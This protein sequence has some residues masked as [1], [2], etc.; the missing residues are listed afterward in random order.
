[1]RIQERQREDVCILDLAGS[2]LLEDGGGQLRDAVAGLL[3]AGKKKLVLNLGGITHVDSGGLG[4]MVQCHALAVCQ[5]ASLKLANLTQRVRD[6]LAI[7]KLV[8]IFDTYER[9]DEAV[10]SF[11]LS[12]A[13]QG[14]GW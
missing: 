12:P 14:A 11:G 6:L 5:G 13:H 2:I 7:T 4:D 9:E 8:T 3:S 10:T 1:M